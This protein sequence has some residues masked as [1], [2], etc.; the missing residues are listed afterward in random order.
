MATIL[1]VDDDPFT[2]GMTGAILE[3][4]GLTVLTAESGDEALAQVAATPG[5]EV[6]VSD[7]NM[8]GMDGLALF[9]ALRRQGYGRPFIL[10]TGD[11]AEPLGRAHPELDAVI[12]KDDQL[13][14][15]LPALIKKLL[16][17]A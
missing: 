13:P 15:L 2:L 11:E 8:P 14:E 16:P 5:V 17:S 1:L 9:A 4:E 12:T 7:M 3:D 10:L 6:V